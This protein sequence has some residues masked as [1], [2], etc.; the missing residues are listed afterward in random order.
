M[1]RFALRSLA[2]RKLRSALTALAIV[3]GVA[4]VSGTYVLTDTIDR[5]F[6]AIFQETYANTDA[7]VAGEGAD[8]SFQGL[9]GPTPP[10]SEDLLDDIRAL[11]SVE[12]A[13][14]TVVNPTDAKILMRDGK[15]V[16]T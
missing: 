5:A 13:A 8:I 14:G 4:M 7:V 2:G 6:T 1:I 12:A 3:L 9:S 16:D 15:A 11:P 10:V